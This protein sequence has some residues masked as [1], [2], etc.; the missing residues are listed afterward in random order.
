[1][2]R[3]FI[4]LT[5]SSDEEET[6][7]PRNRPRRQIPLNADPNFYQGYTPPP[8]RRRRTLSEVTTDD[9]R[10]PEDID[11]AVLV[12]RGVPDFGQREAERFEPYVEPEIPW[13]DDDD[14]ELAAIDAAHWG[15]NPRDRLRLIAQNEATFEDR[16][17][18]R[19]TRDMPPPTPPTPPT[20]TADY[21]RRAEEALQV[22][23]ATGLQWWEQE[24]YHYEDDDS[25]GEQVNWHHYYQVGEAPST[26][27][28]PRTLRR[29]R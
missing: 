27:P 22:P 2:I 17:V 24:T 16:I 3:N 20:P 10:E 14:P 13:L 1:M 18:A 21:M 6:Q 25:D 4:D 29:R 8:P 11:E 26:P 28:H 23:F 5:G 15:G 19:A 12:N 9:E 7:Q